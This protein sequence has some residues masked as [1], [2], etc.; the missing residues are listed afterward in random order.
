MTTDERLARLH[1]S[2]R[3]AAGLLLLAAPARAGAMWLGPGAR[4]P[5]A[6]ALLRCLGVRDLAVGAAILAALRRDEPVRRLFRIG[7]ALEAVDVAVTLTLPRKERPAT[8]ALLVLL[9]SAGLAL[10][11]WLGWRLPR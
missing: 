1:A 9:G 8:A 7:V 4:R 5:A 2:I 10:G 3:V 11:A 6:R